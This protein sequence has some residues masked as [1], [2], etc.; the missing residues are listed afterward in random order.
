[1]S[2]E[3]IDLRSRI[4]KS[5]S[6]HHADDFMPFLE[7]FPLSA[8]R[9]PLG[10]VLVLPGGGYAHRAYHEGAPVAEKFNE[11]GY[12]AFVLQ[13]RVAPYRY[14]APQRDLVRAV[15]LIRSMSAPWRLDKLAV[16]GFSAGAHLAASGTMLADSFSDPQGDEADKFSG[17][18][19]AMILCYPVISLVSNFAN[20]GSGVAL[21]GSDAPDE[22]RR[23]LNMDELVDENTPPTFLW[24]TADDAG[25]PIRNSTSF[26]E[27]MWAKGNS[28]ELHVFPH[29]PHGSGLAMGLYHAKLWPELA[30]E[31]LEN[32]AGFRRV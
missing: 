26:A 24:H 6:G 15:K 31:F 32:P 25:V 22:E 1:M 19:D 10:G 18:A 17:R 2:A 28:C 12:H 13:Y 7:L 29:G 16:L 20:T 27:K 23:K 3:R 4:E 5:P 9:Q 21:F 14:P 30:A 11:L 8:A